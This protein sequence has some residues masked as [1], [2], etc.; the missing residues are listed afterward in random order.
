MSQGIAAAAPRS[1]G[2]LVAFMQNLQTANA[3]LRSLVEVLSG[4]MQVIGRPGAMPEPVSASTP[5]RGGLHE[6]KS[7]MLGDFER[8]GS[9]MFDSIGRLEAIKDQLGSII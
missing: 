9:E 1:Q 6:V 5:S 4:H 2:D 8:E 7:G 3:R